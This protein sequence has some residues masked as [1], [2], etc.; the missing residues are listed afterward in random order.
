MLFIWLALFVFGALAITASASFKLN[1]DVLAYQITAI[2]YIGP[3]FTLLALVM[4][5]HLS[6]SAPKAA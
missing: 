2:I 5:N 3:I 6:S 1:K 4:F